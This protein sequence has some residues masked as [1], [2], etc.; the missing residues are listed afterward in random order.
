VVGNLDEFKSTLQI[1]LKKLGHRERAAFL[2]KKPMRS[3]TKIDNKLSHDEGPGLTTLSMVKTIS[4]RSPTKPPTARSV[5]NEKE[6]TA[7]ALRS[8]I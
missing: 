6:I 5:K 8:L 3:L 4:C 2:S 7:N 1:K